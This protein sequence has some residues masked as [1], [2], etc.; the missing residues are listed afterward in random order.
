MPASNAMSAF[1]KRARDLKTKYIASLPSRLEAISHSLLHLQA[2][3]MRAAALADLTLQ[4]HTL[5]GTAGSYGFA[6]ISD[7]A[8]QA[9]VVCELA[10]FDDDALRCLA[11]LLAD[12]RE[13]ALRH[14][15]AAST[16]SHFT[17]PRSGASA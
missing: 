17:E 11:D 16:Q 14:H 3:G 8:H 5:S 9:E 10:P 7:F 4:V 2:S 15:T 12:L 1:E 13:A 6:D